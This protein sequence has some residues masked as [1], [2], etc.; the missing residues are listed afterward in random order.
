MVDETGN[1]GNMVCIYQSPNII[2]SA[3][4]SSQEYYDSEIVCI[5]LRPPQLAREYSKAV[6]W[7]RRSPFEFE[8]KWIETITTSLK[9]SVLNDICGSGAILGFVGLMTL[10]H[11]GSKFFF[12]CGY[13]VGPKYFLMHTLWV[14][15]FFS[16]WVQDFFLWVFCGSN[17]FSCGYLVGPPF[18]LFGILWVQDF[19][20]WVFC[21]PKI[22]CGYFVGP[23]FFLIGIL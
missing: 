9:L 17:I 6:W 4:L 2:C 22:S 21:G 20:L 19:L 23:I 12:S 8:G 5:L 10:C 7:K 13:F 14:P 3:D 16:L 15:Y 1:M 11:R 18:F